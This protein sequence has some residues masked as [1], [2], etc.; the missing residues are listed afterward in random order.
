MYIIILLFALGEAV[1]LHG[2][3]ALTNSLLVEE[4][5]Q[6]L[7][8]FRQKFLWYQKTLAISRVSFKKSTFLAR[9]L[10][11]SEQELVLCV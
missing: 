1:C 4:C 10:N 11:F 9:F 3:L 5:E 2:C 7:Y 6:F 8:D